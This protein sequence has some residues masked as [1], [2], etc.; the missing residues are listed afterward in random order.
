MSLKKTP[1]AEV[2]ALRGIV[3]ENR[4]SH[5][6]MATHRQWTKE[7][8]QALCRSHLARSGWGYVSDTAA[9][10]EPTVLA[11]LAL[12]VMSL[13]FRQHALHVRIAYFTEIAMI[14]ALLGATLAVFGYRVFRVVWVPI[15]FLAFMNTQDNRMR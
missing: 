15:A 1:T 14:P 4:T 13:V 11:G 2:G 9:Y 10:V 12:L 7:A 6:A 5:T 3:P 8:R